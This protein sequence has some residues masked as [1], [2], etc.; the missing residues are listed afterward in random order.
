VGR[1]SQAV[2]ERICL[3][4]NQI[5]F[6]D[7]R[8]RHRQRFCSQPACRRASHA[9]SQAK[10][11]KQNPDYFRGP[12]HVRRVQKWR[13]AHPGYAR[14]KPAPPLQAVFPLKP[15]APQTVADKPSPPTLQPLQDHSPPLQD[16]IVYKYLMVGL[17]AHQFDCALQED[18][19]RTLRCLI[20]KG[21]DLL[22]PTPGTP[23]L[24][25][26][27]KSKHD[28]KETPPSRTPAPRAGAVQLAGSPPGAG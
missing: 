19:H 9:A 7:G 10:W 2:C 1:V 6:P 3:H 8:N 20:D 17:L 26:N 16:F 14:R 27:P 12:E 23:W 25:L 15:I 5:F 13:Q 18:I 28:A 24:N 21:R 11:L 22:G 4:C